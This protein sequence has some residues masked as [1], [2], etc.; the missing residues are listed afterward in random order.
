MATD[1]EV[2]EVRK[3]VAEQDDESFSNIYIG[4]LVDAVG[5]T[6]ASAAI[7]RKKAASYAELVNVTEAGASHSFSDLQRNALTMAAE[8]DAMALVEVDEASGAG[9][10]QV[11]VIERS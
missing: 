3:N 5:I 4:S 2:A 7:W 6:G 1:A 11:K 9:R 10:V 8:F